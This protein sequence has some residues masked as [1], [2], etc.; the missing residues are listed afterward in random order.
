LHEADRLFFNVL[1]TL[2]VSRMPLPLMVVMEKLSYA[3]VVTS[4]SAPDLEV[5]VA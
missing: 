2:A 5:C 1:I 3:L 4:G